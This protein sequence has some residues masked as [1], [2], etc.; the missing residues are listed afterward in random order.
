VFT[1][2]R[3]ALH[4][5][6]FCITRRRAVPLIESAKKFVEYCQVCLN[7]TEQLQITDVGLKSVSVGGRNILELNLT[8]A[9]FYK[10]FNL[11]MFVISYSDC[12]WPAFTA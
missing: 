9:Q 4:K 6:I 7:F 2:S 10:T 3:A 1:F 8:R 12:P 11:Q 5:L